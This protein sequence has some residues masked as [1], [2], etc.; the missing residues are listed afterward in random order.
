MTRVHAQGHASTR[1][2]SRCTLRAI[3][4]DQQTRAFAGNRTRGCAHDLDPLF[5]E[6]AARFV[7]K[8]GAVVDNQAPQGHTTKMARTGRAHMD[9]SPKNAGRAESAL[10]VNLAH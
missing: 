7:Q 10:V 6:Q 2:A 9:A 1:S 5:L 8:A 3:D 4:A